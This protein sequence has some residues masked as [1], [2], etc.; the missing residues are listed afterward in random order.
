VNPS[1]QTSP[2]IS[3]ATL[4]AIIAANVA[5]V[6]LLLLL[7]DIWRRHRKRRSKKDGDRE[8]PGVLPPIHFEISSL[9][10]ASF[11]PSARIIVVLTM[12]RKVIRK[13]FKRFIPRKLE[14]RPSYPPALFRLYFLC[15]PSDVANL[16]GARGKNRKGRTIFRTRGKAR[17]LLHCGDIEDH[18]TNGK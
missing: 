16:Q 18:R 17:G 1:T 15:Q 11:Y 4:E 10:S 3:G 12:R 5:G 13:P 8:N 6:L 9:V 14:G 2:P 7:F